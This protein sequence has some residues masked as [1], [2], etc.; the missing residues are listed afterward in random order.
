LLRRLAPVRRSLKQLAREHE[1]RVA[2]VMDAGEESE[3]YFELDSRYL[4][5]A[6]AIGARMEFRFHAAF[7]ED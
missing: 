5:L 6:G 2:C 3:A 1:V 7:M 4:L